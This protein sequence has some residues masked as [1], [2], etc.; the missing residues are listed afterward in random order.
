MGE[1][2][3]S[4][5]RYDFCLAVV[6]EYCQVGYA[7]HKICLFYTPN[8]PQEDSE[9]REWFRYMNNRSGICA[10]LE[11]KYRRRSHSFYP[12]PQGSMGK[13][14]LCLWGIVP[15][16]TSSVP[17]VISEKVIKPNAARK[18]ILIDE[19]FLWQNDLG[20]W[21]AGLCVGLNK[22]GGGKYLLTNTTQ[23]EVSRH[24]L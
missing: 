13:E 11:H 7:L 15:I 21:F 22:M 4:E 23:L 9:R 1:V 2:V 8:L 18:D 20:E 24:A 10:Q 16:L 17:P 12:Y 6:R 14:D 5:P 19:F 3:M